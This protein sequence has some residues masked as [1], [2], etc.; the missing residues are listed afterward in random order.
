MQGPYLQ[1][2]IFNFSPSSTVGKNTKNNH[3][4][5]LLMAWPGARGARL[6][7]TQGWFG[8]TE[9]GGG[10]LGVGGA[11]GGYTDISVHVIFYIFN[12]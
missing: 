8:G 11:G 12:V 3:P 4:G 7:F 9:K 10:K 5:V 2:K 6:L 1:T